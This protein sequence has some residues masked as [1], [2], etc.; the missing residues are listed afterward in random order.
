M[1]L[2]NAQEFVAAMKGDGEFRAVVTGFADSLKLR[3]FLVSQGYEFDLPDL[4][5]AMVACMAEL[6]QDSQ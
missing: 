3:N 2:A 4:I 5:R 6:P 1:S